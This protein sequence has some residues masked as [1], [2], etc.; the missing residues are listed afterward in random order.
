MATKFKFGSLVPSYFLLYSLSGFLRIGGKQKGI[1]VEHERTCLRPNFLL[2]IGQDWAFF[3]ENGDITVGVL[4]PGRLFSPYRRQLGNKFSFRSR[5]AERRKRYC[6]PIKLCSRLKHFL[7]TNE[8]IFSF[9]LSLMNICF[10]N[11]AQKTVAKVQQKS[12]FLCNFE[13]LPKVISFINSEFRIDYFK[14]S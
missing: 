1:W 7:E 12:L 10:A 6:F 5:K 2:E 4:L 14:Y 13:P 8:E 9:E 3:L 11:A